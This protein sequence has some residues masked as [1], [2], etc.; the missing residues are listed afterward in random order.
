[1]AS[2]SSILAW[3]T[4]WTG[5][6]Q[7][8]VHRVAKNWTRLKHLSMQ[9]TEILLETLEILGSFPVHLKFGVTESKSQ[10]LIGFVLFVCCHISSLPSLLE[11]LFPTIVYIIL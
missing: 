8:T 1:M 4:P 9:N 7:A 11:E 5:A 2:Y 10:H 6:W 3:R